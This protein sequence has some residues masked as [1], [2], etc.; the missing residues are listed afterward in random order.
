MNIN[1]PMKGIVRTKRG[2]G[3]YLN[4]RLSDGYSSQNDAQFAMNSEE[5]I[6]NENI[7]GSETCN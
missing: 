5:E 2:F 6:L 4:G 7:I 1:K 3:Y